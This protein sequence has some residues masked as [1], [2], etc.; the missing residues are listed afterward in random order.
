MPGLTR[1]SGLHVHPGL[2]DAS[3]RIGLTE[4]GSVHGTNDMRDLATYQPDL[5]AS[6]AV[7]PH[8]AHV[9]IARAAGITSVLVQPGGGCTSGQSSL[10]HLNGWTMP[11]MLFA[12]PVALHMG[13]PVLPVHLTGKDKKKRKK[14]HEESLR[15]LEEWVS[16]A[17]RYATQ[18]ESSVSL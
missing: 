18:R 11:E 3:S 9:R 13:V 12:D 5:R 17:Q 4:I 1:P 8:S 2:I 6:S 7:N 14:S 10:I 15:E 16:R